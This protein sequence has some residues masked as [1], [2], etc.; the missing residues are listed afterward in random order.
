MTTRQRTPTVAWSGGAAMM[1]D[2]FGWVAM[3]VFV[4]LCVRLVVP[5]RADLIGPSAVLLAVLGAMLGG[6]VWA[7]VILYPWTPVNNAADPA[8]LIPGMVV[9]AGS[10]AVML[11]V[12]A[13][14]TSHHPA[15]GPGI[16]A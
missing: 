10:A 12:Y 8:R 7:A 5:G 4:G 2:A 1:W 9:A 16:G 13:A 3:G 14:A 11:R 15:E 6:Y